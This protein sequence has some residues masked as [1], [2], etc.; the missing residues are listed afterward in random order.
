M[1]SGRGAYGMRSSTSCQR[2]ATAAVIVS[3]LHATTFA[4][5]VRYRA[6]PL[7]TIPF[8]DRAIVHERN[9]VRVSASALGHDEA[10]TLFGVPLAKHGIQPVWLRITNETDDTYLFFQQTVDPNYYAPVEAAYRSHFSGTKRVLSLGLVAVFLWPVILAAPVPYL[11]ARIANRRMDELFESRGIGNHYI[12]PGHTIE[13]FVFTRVDEG[14]KKVPV[15]LLGP[16]GTRSFD[17]FVQVPGG[18]ADYARIDF[19]TLHARDT[20]RDI[21]DDTLQDTLAA[22]PCCTTNA[23]GTRNGDPLNLVIVGTFEQLLTE[24]TRAGWDE[25]DVL[26]LASGARTAGAFLFGSTYRHSPVSELFLYGRSQDVTFQK[27]RDTIHGRNHLRLW[28]APLRL[29]GT[30]IWVGQVSR[31][32]GIRFTTTTWNLT[33]HAIDPN[34]DDSREAIVGDL[35]QT[36]R[37]AVVGYLAG[38]DAS[39]RDAPARNLSGDRYHTDGYRALTILAEEPM[40]PEFFPAGALDD[41]GADLTIE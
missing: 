5:C 32:I 14:T 41:S 27:A 8:Q 19:E 31:D 24:L 1:G 10:R 39:T 17:L 29:N 35:L 22:L 9:G 11:S 3:L 13:G 25:T 21:D 2:A 33:T 18:N 34:V 23:R 16:T 38:F 40:A 26:T 12:S 37:V 7:D 15:T 20:I 6:A 30:P 36:G 4:G 28:L